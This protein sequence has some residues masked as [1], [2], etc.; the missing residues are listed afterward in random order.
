MINPAGLGPAAVSRPL[1]HPPSG[2]S[3]PGAAGVVRDGKGRGL[4][5]RSGVPG[6]RAGAPERSGGRAA[7]VG[8]GGGGGA[9]PPE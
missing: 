6:P 7:G 8:C 4:R 5:P 3:G 2:A 9:R 1:P